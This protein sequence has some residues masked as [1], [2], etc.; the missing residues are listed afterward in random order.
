MPVGVE[1]VTVCALTYLRPK[2]LRWLL[3]GLD[4]LVVPAG[5][6]VS[7]VIVDNDPDESARSIVDERAGRSA[8]D[9]AYVAEPARGISHA[10]NA[11]VAA[12]RARGADAVAFIDDDEWPDPSWLTELLAT[13]AA[14]GADIVTGPVFPVFEEPPPRWVTDGGFFERRR[15]E[16]HERIR[17]ATTSTV[18]LTTRSIADRPAPFDPAFGLSGGEDTHLFAELRE[19][20]FVSVW[21]DRAHVFETIPPSR[22]DARWLLRREYRRGQTLSLSLRRRRPTVV[23]RLRRVAN[24]LMQVSAGV[25]SAVIGLGRGR[26]ARFAGVQRAVFGAGMLT[27]LAG[28]RYQEYETTHGS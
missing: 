6:T 5:I 20:G 3:D 11:A 14:T 26:A 17:Y 7:V 18:L 24:G 21:C 22:V 13:M 15:H 9:V 12:A 25:A 10:R 2:G 16:H 27:G 8:H 23:A 1:R 19:A 28:R 4:E